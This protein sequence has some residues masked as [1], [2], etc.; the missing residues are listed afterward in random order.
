MAGQFASARRR[1]DDELARARAAGDAEVEQYA[2]T[3]LLFAGRVMALEDELRRR[4]PLRQLL[5]SGAGSAASGECTG[6]SDNDAAN[7]GKAVV[8][9]ELYRLRVQHLHDAHRGEGG[10]AAEGAEVGQ[11]QR[12]QRLAVVPDAADRGAYAARVASAVGLFE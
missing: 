5:R 3:A 4:R 2:R 8:E 10:G 11:R 1:L 12:Q 7:N 9:D 6:A